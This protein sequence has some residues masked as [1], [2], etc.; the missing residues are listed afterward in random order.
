MNLVDAIRAS[1]AVAE[2]LA[3]RSG[4]AERSSLRERQAMIDFN[5]FGRV[6]QAGIEE[7]LALAKKPLAWGVGLGLPALG[8][9]HALISDAHSH[10]KDLVHD[11]RNQ[12]LLTA[13]GVGGM[14][15]LGSLIQ[16]ASQ[17]RPPAEQ[18]QLPGMETRLASDLRTD[19]MLESACRT[20]TTVQE[21][22]AAL[23]R[24]IRHRMNAMAVV[25]GLIA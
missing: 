19:D 10:A 14:Q 15:S 12:A 8:V 18:V 1:S 4:K 13:A 7:T 22:H 6:K 16:S 24:L 25:R 11:A 23:V 2:K 3:S 9:G 21:K 17:R 5:A 20:G